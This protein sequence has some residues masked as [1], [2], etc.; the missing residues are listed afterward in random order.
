MNG[1]KLIKYYTKGL[2]LYNFI[3]LNVICENTENLALHSDLDGHFHERD[4]ISFEGTTVTFMLE[5]VLNN[6]FKTF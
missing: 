5:Y 6:F 3:K 4:Y 1:M 2:Y